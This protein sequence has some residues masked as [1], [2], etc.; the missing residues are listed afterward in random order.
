MAI[1][2]SND[3]RAKVLEH[4]I[5]QTNTNKLLWEYSNQTQQFTDI[6]FSLSAPIISENELIAND[7]NIFRINDSNKIEKVTSLEGIIYSYKDERNYMVNSSG[8]YL[9]VVTDNVE[10]TYYLFDS[11]FNYLN[12]KY[13]IQEN[14]RVLCLSTNLGT[15]FELQ[16]SASASRFSEFDK[17]G[18]VIGGMYNLSG[19]PLII[20]QAFNLGVQTDS[21]TGEMP[22]KVILRINGKDV[23]LANNFVYQVIFRDGNYIISTMS[24]SNIN[25]KINSFKIYKL[26]PQGDL[27]VLSQN[28]SGIFIY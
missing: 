7:K 26:S 11:Q 13:I 5:I 15:I 22:P 24:E 2:N 20:Y 9:K 25:N 16:K 6:P 14:E 8:R 23:N 19:N 4:I 17:S 28:A 12:C 3:D 21:Q 1:S 10:N 18:Y 27:Q